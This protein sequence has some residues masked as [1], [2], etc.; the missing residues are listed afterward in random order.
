L[1]S[2]LGAR[3]TFDYAPEGIE[4]RISIPYEAPYVAGLGRGPK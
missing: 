1:K 4:V 2:V 3:V